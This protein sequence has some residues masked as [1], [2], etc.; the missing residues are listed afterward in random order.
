M[1]SSA[2]DMKWGQIYHNFVYQTILFSFVALQSHDGYQLQKIHV[3]VLETLM[4]T[5][6]TN[7]GRGLYFINT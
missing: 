1:F 2:T 5:L 7:I 4:L 6:P 3:C